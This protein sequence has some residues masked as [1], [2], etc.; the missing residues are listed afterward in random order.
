M[1]KVLV[2]NLGDRMVMQR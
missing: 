2:P 1:T